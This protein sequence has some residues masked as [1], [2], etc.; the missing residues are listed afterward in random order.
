MIDEKDN[1]HN[2]IVDPYQLHISQRFQGEEHTC[3]ESMI[4]I[5]KSKMITLRMSKLLLHFISLRSF[6]RRSNKDT[7][8]R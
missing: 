7:W 4:N 3:F 1:V 6:I 8:N 5:E 2:T